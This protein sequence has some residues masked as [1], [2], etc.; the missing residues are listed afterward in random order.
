MDLR[1]YYSKVREAEAALTG[2]H[3]IM[4]SLATSE[5]G[6]AGVRTEVPRQIAA[7]LIAEGR[8]RVATPEEA[9]EFHETHREA[10]L[11]HEQQESARRIQ[12]MVIPQQEL[13]K[14]ES[15][16]SD[17]GKRDRG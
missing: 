1:V 3:T 10:R 8:A 14:S 12:V 7:R 4:V 5:G 17:A 6:K 13:K 11:K 2:E 9:E 15:V 16:R